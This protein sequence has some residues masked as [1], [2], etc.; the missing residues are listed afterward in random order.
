MPATAIAVQE[1][2][3]RVHPSTWRFDLTLQMRLF[4][5]TDEVCVVF[6][7]ILD[8]APF[9]A[10]RC[11]I[12]TL[13]QCSFAY[14]VLDGDVAK[15][16]GY[17]H[18]SVAKGLLP[19]SQRV[20]VQRPQPRQMQEQLLHPRQVQAPRPSPRRQRPQPRRLPPRR[21]QAQLPP[22]RRRDDWCRCRGC[23]LAGRSSSRRHAGHRLAGCRRSGPGGG[24]CR[25]RRLDECR[26]SPPSVGF[27]VDQRRPAVAAI[28]GRGPAAICSRVGVSPA[29]AVDFVA[30]LSILLQNTA[31]SSEQLMPPP[32]A[33]AM[34]LE[35]A[36]VVTS[37]VGYLP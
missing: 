22:P 13:K 8:N 28:D 16:S 2:L 19:S 37:T 23:S 10:G 21:M 17:L 24:R 33:R 31:P 11:S 3:D 30:V 9:S 18:A 14:Y 32:L 15:I 25:G 20:Q 29:V 34:L 36:S 27:C 5:S 4:S 35:C 6:R 7:L 1:G 26:P 12:H